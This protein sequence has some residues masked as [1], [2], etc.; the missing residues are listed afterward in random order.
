MVALPTRSVG[1]HLAVTSDAQPIL[2][3]LRGETPPAAGGEASATAKAPKVTPADVKVRVLNGTGTAG[4]A[5]DTA[6]EL[7]RAGFSPSGSGD[8][9]TFGYARTEIH[10]PA[11]A[12]AKAAFLAR[13]LGGAGKLV[14]DPAVKGTDLV[15]I[16]GTDWKGVTAPAGSQGGGQ[17]AAAPTTT[18]APTTAGPTTAT[19]PAPKPA[20]P[21]QPAC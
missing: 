21:S 11:A 15:L 8:A 9:D 19:G 10:Y 13:Y 6:G 20:G 17:A 1:A 5:G 16:V 2:A 12:Q 7:S 14:S 4:V 18:P 3:R